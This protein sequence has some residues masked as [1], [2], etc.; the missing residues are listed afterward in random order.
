MQVRKHPSGIVS[1]GEVFVYRHKDSDMIVALTN[2]CEATGKGSMVDDKPEIVCR[3]CYKPVDMM[4]GDYA[5]TEDELVS[6][7]MGFASEADA[8]TAFNMLEGS[9]V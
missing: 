4:F 7:L 2:C 8:R 6:L 3:K 9:L 1:V 5:V